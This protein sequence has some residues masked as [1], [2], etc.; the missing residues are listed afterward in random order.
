MI[1]DLNMEKLNLEANKALKNENEC[2]RIK[3]RIADTK[4]LLL[5]LSGDLPS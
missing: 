5:A 4:I 2:L 3:H 1:I